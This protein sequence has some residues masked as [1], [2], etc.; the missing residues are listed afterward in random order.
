MGSLAVPA[1]GP[2]YV[3]A[4]VVIYSVEKHPTYAPLL[5]PLWAA[6]QAGTVQA[7]TSELTELEV[8]VGPLKAGD[9]PLV[10]RYDQFLRL[11]G[12]RLVPISRPTLRDA[13]RL[14]ATTAKLRTPDAI[15]LA[16]ALRGRCVQLVT[17]DLTFRAV[18]GLPV[19]ILND[20]LPTP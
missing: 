1:G 12:V 16:T 18:P 3:D 8:L 14:R 15:H 7:V 11:P 4:Q 13:A 2:V 5:R 17:S 10:A 20:L 9:A 19:V 6:V